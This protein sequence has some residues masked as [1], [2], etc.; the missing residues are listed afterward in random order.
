MALE[1]RAYNIGSTIF[2]RD[3]ALV[4]RSTEE[5][6]SEARGPFVPFVARSDAAEEL[7]AAFCRDLIASARALLGSAFAP[8]S[9]SHA[10]A[11]ASPTPA[12]QPHR[13]MELID[14]VDAGISALD[15]GVGEVSAV[16]L[17]ELMMVVR[18]F[19]HWEDHPRWPQIQQSLRNPPDFPHAVITLAAGSLLDDAGNSVVLEP[20]HPRGGR[21][22]DLRLEI[23]PSEGVSTEVKAPSA[24][25]GPLTDLPSDQARR[26]VEKARRSAGTGSRGQIGQGRSGMLIIGGFHLSEK[27]VTTLRDAA[28][29]LLAEVPRPNLTAIALVSVGVVVEVGRAETRLSPA[30]SL[31]VAENPH[32]S[33][34]LTLDTSQSAGL[35][36]FDL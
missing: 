35:R 11:K 29:K 13:L 32:Y 19:R 16:A 34:T 3:V 9:E 30:L 12:R 21:A 17:A 18:I 7:D 26:V 27:G 23:S 2:G 24:L 20:G 5:R 14:L 6:A 25:Q 28:G 36:Q 10:R 8:I 1:A 15:S 22:A 31:E 4:S 33:G